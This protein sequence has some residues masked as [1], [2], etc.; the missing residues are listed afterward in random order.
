MTGGEAEKNDGSARSVPVG[1]LGARGEQWVGSFELQEGPGRECLLRLTYE[2]RQLKAAGGDYFEA[3]CTIRLQLEK[4][5]H[6][7]RCYGASRN[8][9]PSG[10]ARDM[11][12]GLKAYRLQ[13]GHAASMA[14]LVSIFDDGP[15]VEPVSV[16]TQRAYYESWLTSLGR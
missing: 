7:I 5:G 16:G 2:S 13:K 11:G 9:Y 8:V 4:L 6:S 14:D 12:A 1:V 10:M 15:D 3:L